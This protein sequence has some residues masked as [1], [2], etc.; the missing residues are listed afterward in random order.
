MSDQAEQKTFR[1]SELVSIDITV[2]PRWFVVEG[3]PR[4][5]DRLTCL[6][7]PAKFK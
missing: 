1:L 3:D 6:V 5:P 4:K 7:I 2:E